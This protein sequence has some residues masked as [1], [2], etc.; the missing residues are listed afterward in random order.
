MSE[1]AFD[2]PLCIEG[3]HV[4]Y[5]AGRPKAN[6]TSLLLIS[7]QISKQTTSA[8]AR[9]FPRGIDYKLDIMLAEEQELWPT[10]L[11]VP[12][13]TKQ[14]GALGV[15]FQIFGVRKFSRDAGFRGGCGKGPG[16]SSLVS[17]SCFRTPLDT[18]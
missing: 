6:A 8:L 18:A 3:D 7:R 17:T 11:S 14:V 15:S 12:A 1:R 9:L 13:V 10:W 2:P 4:R 5:E 16:I